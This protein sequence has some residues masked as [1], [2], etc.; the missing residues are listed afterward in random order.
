MFSYEANEGGNFSR[1]VMKSDY[2]KDGVFGRWIDYRSVHNLENI[3]FRLGR[4]EFGIDY[5]KIKFRVID[6]E[7]NSSGWYR[8][9]LNVKEVMDTFHGTKGRD[10]MKGIDGSNRLFGEDGNDRFRSGEYNDIYIGGEGRDT[11]EFVAGGGRDHVRDFTKGEDRIDV[12]A[13][14]NVDNLKALRNHVSQ[15]DGSMT[16]HFGGRGDDDNTLILD[17]VRFKDLDSRDF[18]F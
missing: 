15:A 18:E 1:V 9:T 10:V 12:S 8:I 16:I 11:F 2:V 7:G 5:S 14:L 13:L 4:D 6:D 17:H 3:P